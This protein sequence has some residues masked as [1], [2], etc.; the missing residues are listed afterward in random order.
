MAGPPGTAG[1][2]QATASTVHYRLP[3][4][5]RWAVIPAGGDP[6]DPVSLR[7]PLPRRLAD[8]LLQKLADRFDVPPEIGQACRD[9]RACEC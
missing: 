3:G 8:S 2:P 7:L 1:V 9:G 5:F 4:R 6:V